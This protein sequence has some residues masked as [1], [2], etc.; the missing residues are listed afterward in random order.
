VT[1][2]LSDYGIRGPWRKSKCGVCG[3]E[4]SCLIFPIGYY[5]GSDYEGDWEAM[6][7][8]CLVKDIEKS[9]REEVE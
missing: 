9:E 2:K 1:T 4:R 6:C 7:V 8:P 3:E 5:I